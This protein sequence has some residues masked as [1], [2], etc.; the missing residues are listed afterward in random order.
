MAPP[1]PPPVASELALLLADPNF[2]H[3]GQSTLNAFA[4]G[5]ADG[6]DILYRLLAEVKERA[7]ARE[8][9]LA[10][11]A[12]EQAERA[13]IDAEMAANVKATGPTLVPCAADGTP[14]PKK[15]PASVLAATT[16]PAP[17][18][19]A[20]SEDP[21]E[22]RF[23]LFDLD[24]PTGP[25]NRPVPAQP[26]PVPA[27]LLGTDNRLLLQMSEDVAAGYR[28]WEL[29]IGDAL[30]DGNFD[31][32]HLRDI[33][34]YLLQD[35]YAAPGATRGDEQALGTAPAVPGDVRLGR[36]GQPLTLLPP[37]R[38][39]DRLD[40]LGGLLVQENYLSGLPKAQFVAR[41]A[42]YHAAYSQAAPFAA[43]NAHVL[44]VVLTQIGVEAGYTVKPRA[45][46]LLNE[47]THAVVAAGVNS[48]KTRLMAV[49][50]AVVQEA[51]GREAELS[52]RITA[53]VVT[54]EGPC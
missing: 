2:Q 21:V 42:A 39:N 9:A 18:R 33:H 1:F 16:D 48:D 30:A 5:E 15:P 13:R 50:A 12:H 24:R 41:L 7:P 22:Q 14:L 6:E 40:A 54:P 28:A 36:T 52:R 19:A 8:V 34:A 43:G 45:S 53:R 4:A 3:P 35:I 49:L 23:S 47:V 37:E 10:A 44:G 29:Q 25:P 20:A 27:N 51:P 17:A 38:V 11:A 32:A 46:R 26:L 31:A